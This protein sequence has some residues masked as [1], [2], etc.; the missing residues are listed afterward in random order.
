MVHI[1]VMERAGAD[2]QRERGDVLVMITALEVT[3]KGDCCCS[4][5][6]SK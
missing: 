1:S 5:R 2:T 4:V 3:V 6:E